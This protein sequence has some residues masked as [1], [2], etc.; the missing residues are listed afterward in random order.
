LEE[1]LGHEVNAGTT[2]TDVQTVRHITDHER[3]CRFTL[4]KGGYEWVLGQNF[5]HGYSSV[6]DLKDE[7]M[8]I[9]VNQ[10]HTYD[11]YVVPF[12][13]APYKSESPEDCYPML[14]YE[15]EWMEMMEMESEVSLDGLTLPPPQQDKPLLP[16][17]DGSAALMMLCLAG[18]GIGISFVFYHLL[19]SKAPTKK[20]IR[21]T[22]GRNDARTV[23]AKEIEALPR[24][25]R[26]ALKSLL[27]AGITRDSNNLM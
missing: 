14:G 20:E 25:E 7:K 26:E 12:K 9:G 21:L 8:Y 24:E 4:G 2:D 6:F 11:Y 3:I 5:F 23:S 16:T 1:I 13:R 15:A 27:L 19:N 10:C 17:I 22:N 18:A